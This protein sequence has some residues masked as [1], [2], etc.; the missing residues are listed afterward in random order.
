MEK[1]GPNIPDQ[2]GMTQYTLFPS[3]KKRGGGGGHQQRS[4]K[5]PEKIHFYSSSSG[6]RGNEPVTQN[7]RI[8]SR[9]SRDT[10]TWD[11]PGSNFNAFPV[12]K[13]GSPSPVPATSKQW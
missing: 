8:M 3:K 1:L 6:S 2:V 4:K 7:Y 13:K 5:S 11:R 12:I 10:D 9:K